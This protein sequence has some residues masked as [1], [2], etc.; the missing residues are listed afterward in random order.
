MAMV[1]DQGRLLGRWN[2][3]DAMVAVLLLGLVPLGYGAYALFRTPPPRLTAVTP[4]TLAAGPNLRV[5][6]T[7]ENLRPYLRVSFG[8][9][10][11]ISFLFNNT[12]EAEVELGDLPP[13]VYDVVLYDVTQERSRLPKALT[14]TPSPLPETEVIVVG[15]LGNLRPD[16]VGDVKAGMAIP[17]V[18]SVLKVGAAIPDLVRAIAGSALVDIPVTKMLR[19]PVALRA[20][21]H[22]RAPQGVPQCFGEGSVLQPTALVFL[23][24]SLGKLPLQIDQVRGTEPTE[25]VRV[26]ARMGGLS[27]VL[28]QI[29]I[30]DVDL[31]VA[32]NELAA[33]AR[34][35]AVSPAAGGHVE[36]TL[37][38]AAQRTSGGL[39]YATAP[40]RIG[41]GVVMRTPEYEAQG[42]VS[43]LVPVPALATDTRR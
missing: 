5:K 30:G 24:T 14:V 21:C 31:G 35:V 13:G 6:I 22:V 2:I 27:D 10:Q 17:G 41:G 38:I 8:T 32:M 7:G 42:I 15:M 1:D 33:G 36:V 25:T 40:L 29:R 39:T 26:T 18:G 20:A 19:L 9:V 43:R 11:G 3:V 16:Q 23:E 28:S 4:L 37:V 34:V 12:T